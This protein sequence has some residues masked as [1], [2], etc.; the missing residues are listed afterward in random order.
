MTHRHSPAATTRTVELD[1]VRQIDRRLSSPGHPGITAG[2]LG[3]NGTPVEGPLLFAPPMFEAG[4]PAS[5]VLGTRD[6]LRHIEAK[7][8]PGFPY[9]RGQFE[10]PATGVLRAAE[11][12]SE[13]LHR[14]CVAMGLSQCW[15]TDAVLTGSSIR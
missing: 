8:A 2:K 3:L 12:H 13:A 6:V 15:G 5:P 7:G 4:L 9:V 10:D 1:Q 14:L 11:L